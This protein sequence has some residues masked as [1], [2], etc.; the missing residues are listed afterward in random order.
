MDAV[1]LTIDGQRIRVPAGTTILEAARLVGIYIPSLCHH[2]D[3]PPADGSLAVAAVYQGSRKTDN[4]L[5]EKRGEGCGICVVEIEGLPDPVGSCVTPVGEGV[6]IMTRNE[7]ID[8]KRRENFVEIISRHPHACLTCAQQ[9]GCSR[10]RCSANVPE[11]ERCCPRFG[12]CELQD[13]AN[14]LGMPDATPRWVP[15]DLPIIADLAL[16]D[17]DYNLCIGC[18]R[19]VRVC[20]DLRGIEALG[21]VYDAADRVQ[22]GSVSETLEDSGCKFCTAC[23]AV[24]P[25]GALSDRTL[26]PV[27]R[28]DELVPCSAAC[29][30]RIDVPGYLR[31]IA[32]GNRTGAGAVIREKVPFPGILGRVCPAPCETVCRRA[33]VNDAISICALK[34]YAAEGDDGLWKRQCR[35]GSD[36]GRRI[37]VIGAGPA[38]L[39]AAF[40]LRKLGHA[41][42]VFE[43]EDKAG[44]MMR[45][46]IPAYRLPREVLDGEIEEILTLGIDFHPNRTLGRDFTLD[47]LWGDGFD[48][49]FLAVGAQRGERIRLEGCES[50]GVLQG[51][52][53][54][55]RV[56]SGEDIRLRG[57]VMVVGGGNVAVD[58][59]MT[60]KRCGA[61]S[62]TLVCLESAEGMPAGKRQIEAAKAEGVSIMPSWG[63]Y[64]VVNAGGKVSGIELRECTVSCDEFGRFC[65]EFGERRERVP[66]DQVIMAVGQA[67]D[68]SFLEARDPIKI[69][70]GRI[71]VNPDTMATNATGIYA[72]GDVI[73]AGGTV[74]HAVAAGR[75]AAKAIDK[76]L[77][78]RGNIDEVLL[79]R[80]APDPNL[81][82]DRGFARRGRVA[83]PEADTAERIASFAEIVLGYSEAQAVAEAER[84]LQCDLRLQLGCNPPPPLDRRMLDQTHVNQVPET[85]GVFQLLDRNRKVISIKGTDNLRRDLLMAVEDAGGA[86]WFMFE[87]E[88][89]YSK[90]ESELLQ[91]H[92]QAHGKMPGGVDDGLD[93][94]Y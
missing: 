25:T 1:N 24:C 44:G 28:E 50:P 9:Q 33:Q 16:F 63:L 79:E 64:R 66:V 85:E 89:M 52:D 26:G 12:S 74:I 60:A 94:L 86:V 22:V 55:R 36:T 47:S 6:V 80:D 35:T 29:P 30:V 2:P 5:P 14:Y 27:V 31:M 93:D 39:T 8:A 59:A 90:R 53:F 37:A 45:Y 38:G 20:R 68:L 62:V 48:S 17:W 84:C 21:F 70:R 49:I 32:Q 65:P 77:G 67:P 43:S 72:G 88:M 81:G 75:K 15:A 78:G 10:T 76:A 7:R 61:A 56:A 3:L 4:H 51:V 13:I 82:R 42:T 73:G 83:V 58:A 54:L 46:G 92:L 91:R 11:N 18:T 71:V 87:E 69:E 23:V 41:V 57:R 34:R 19:C 40:Y